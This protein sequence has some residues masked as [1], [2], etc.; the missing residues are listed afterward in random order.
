MIA[1]LALSAVVALGSPPPTVSAQSTSHATCT[2]AADFVGTQCVPATPGRHPAIVLLGGSEGGDSM[3]PVAAQWAARGYVAASVA[4]FGAPGLPAALENIPVETVGKA[5]ESL[6][7]RDDVDAKRF[8]LMGVSKGGELALAV[9]S[10]YAQ[11]HAVI[12]DVPSS[13][14][15]QGIPIGQDFTPKSSWTI[16]GRPLAYVPYTAAMGAAFGNAFV[17]HEPL[18]MRPGYDDAMKN[19]AAVT[20]ATFPLEKIAGPVLFLAADD[21]RIWD[22]AAQ[23][24]IGM[25]QLQ[26]HAHPYADRYVHYARAGHLFLFAT[27]ARPMLQAPFGGGLTIA[28]GGTAAGNVAAGRAARAEIQA[29]LDAAWQ[30]PAAK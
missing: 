27:P 15:W 29:F 26:A 20:A 2:K 11:I 10:H 8:A 9:A 17:K 6:E 5:I 13:F 28:F 19:V 22:S 1:V 23:S 4:Y 16:D 18:D 7:K 12:A 14:A 25:N 3:A 24:T 30:A 21:D